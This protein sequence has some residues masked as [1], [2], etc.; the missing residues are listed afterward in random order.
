MSKLKMS[1]TQQATPQDSVMIE[2]QQATTQDSAMIETQQRLAENLSSLM[3]EYGMI[4]LPSG[5]ICTP[6]SSFVISS[7]NAKRWIKSMPTL[8]RQ[9]KALFYSRF[10]QLANQKRNGDA[11]SLGTMPQTSFSPEKGPYFTIPSTF[12]GSQCHY[13]VS[14][15]KWDDCSIG[16][17][18]FLKTLLNLKIAHQKE[19]IAYISRKER[20][21]NYSAK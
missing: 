2:I 19:Q 1:E 8:F 6:D 20:E 17:D 5:A 11:P 9:E 7:E 16:D 14:L 15:E 4:L 10:E 12:N 13:I 3:K 18:V 21:K